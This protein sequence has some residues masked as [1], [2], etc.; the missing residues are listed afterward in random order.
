MKR[1]LVAGL[2]WVAF[3]PVHAAKPDP[4]RHPTPNTYRGAGVGELP[5]DGRAKVIREHCPGGG[6]GLVHFLEVDGQQ[7]RVRGTWPTY[8]ELAPGPHRLTMEFVGPDAGVRGTW[9][10][11]ASVALDAVAGQVYVVRYRRVDIDG[12]RVWVEPFVAQGF[13]EVGVSTSYCDHPV[14]PDPRLHQ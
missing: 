1:L 13:A 10:G 14:Y 2:A 11:D 8:L 5:P 4:A 7:I 6:R 3:A 12:F 9:K